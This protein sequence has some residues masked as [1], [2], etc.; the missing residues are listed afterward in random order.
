MQ[1]KIVIYTKGY[2]PYCKAT[3]TLLNTKGVAFLNH[4]ITND[5]DLRR[6]MIA[7]SNGQTTVPQIFIDNFH[8][9]GNSELTA[10][11]RA[12]KLDPLLNPA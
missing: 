7:R 5:P 6:E 3:K 11:D 4:D 2:C 8:V 9:G 10:L 1:P 12:G